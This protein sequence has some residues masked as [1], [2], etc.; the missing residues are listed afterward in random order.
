MTAKIAVFPDTRRDMYDAYAELV[1]ASGARQVDLGE[2]EALLWADPASS[3]AFP[4][5]IAAA[6]NV[7]WIQLPYAGVETFVKYLDN[8]HTWRSEER[9]VGKE[10]RS[11]WSPYH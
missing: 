11:R 3:T 8:D 10:C 5:A 1:E 7:T 6:P 9:R 4:A 2:A